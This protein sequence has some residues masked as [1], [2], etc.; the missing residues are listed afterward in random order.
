MP[1]LTEALINLYI[2]SAIASFGYIC[3]DYIENSENYFSAALIILQDPLNK[4]LLY[5]FIIAL[6]TLLYRI[7]VRLFYV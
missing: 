6:T 5:N 1:T 4:L 7:N 2:V 3:Y